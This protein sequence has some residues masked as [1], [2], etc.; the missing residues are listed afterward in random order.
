[1]KI[2][3]FAGVGIAILLLLLAVW[4]VPRDHPGVTTD[5]QGNI[6]MQR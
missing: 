2:L 6:I 5:R 1:L 4:V 3:V